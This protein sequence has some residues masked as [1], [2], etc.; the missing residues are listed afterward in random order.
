MIQRIQT[1]WLALAAI[2]GG[3]SYQ[4]P[5]YTGIRMMGEPPQPTPGVDMTATYSIPII[6]AM[7]IAVVGAIHAIFSYYKRQHQFVG[8]LVAMISSIVAIVLLFMAMSDFESGGVRIESLL[9]FAV[10][11]FLFLAAKGI[12]N[13]EKLVRSMDRLR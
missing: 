2:C 13:D 9:Y 7:A 10:P 3:L 4:F 8:T 12:R 6:I 11:V 5:F 1:L